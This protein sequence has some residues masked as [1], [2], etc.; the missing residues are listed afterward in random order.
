MKIGERD[1]SSEHHYS[2]YRRRS[3]KGRD[4]YPEHGEDENVVAVVLPFDHRLDIVQNRDPFFRLG[5]L[6]FGLR[7]FWLVFHSL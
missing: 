6:L 1:E 2:T 5:L 7:R 4:H 3:D